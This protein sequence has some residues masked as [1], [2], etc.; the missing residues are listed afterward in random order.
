MPQLE[1]ATIVMKDAVNVLIG[2]QKDG[3]DAG[4]W[5]IPSG[6]IREG[7][8]M[9]ETCE[10]VSIEETGIVVK[11][12]Q[13]LFLSEVLKP[14]HRTAV[15]CFADYVSGEP[16]P[17]ASLTEVKFV[18]PRTLG[19]YQKEGMAELTEDAFFKFSMVLRG[20]AAASPTSGIV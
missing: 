13:V 10:R 5:V 1:V 15:F 11:P 14:E 18:D 8:R 7:E 19:D 16:S 2:K 12:K 3:P 9:I 4:K 20:Q 6:L 17:G